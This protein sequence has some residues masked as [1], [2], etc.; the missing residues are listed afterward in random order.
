MRIIRFDSVGGASGDMILGALI[1][2]GVNLDELNAEL[3]TLVPEKFEI[4]T[5]PWQSYGINN[6]IQAEVV[7]H[8]HEHHHHHHHEDHGHEHHHHHGRNF[9]D[10][11]HLIDSSGLED[12]VKKMS[13]EVFGAL[14][15]AEAKVHG[16][17]P[18]EVHFH[19]VGA[20]D[21]IVDIVG[22]CLAFC[23]LEADAISV[24]PLPTG[25]GTFDC[26]HGTY[27]LPAPATM[28]MLKHG[29][30]T[31]PT[32]EPY[33]LLTPTGAALL[34][35]W[36]KAEIG[37]DAVIKKSA[38]SFGHRELKKRPNLLRASIYEE[39]EKLLNTESLS[40]LETNIDDSTPELIGYVFDKLLDAGALDV[41]T[42]A[43]L[44]KKQ[45]Q[46][47]MLSV[48][49]E[50]SK[51]NELINLILTET[52]SLG[53]REYKVERNCLEYRFEQKTTPYGDV[54][55]KIASHK[56]RD[57]TISPEFDDCVRLAEKCGVPLKE[58][59][60]IASS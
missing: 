15:E 59:M 51:N 5:Q 24:S 28:E 45:R 12:K 30:K 2:L 44:M 52:S 7:I 8:K 13:L 40:V 36:P 50:K 60:R 11:K 22:C 10:I 55:V 49:C 58:I 54:K 46:G 14:A 32:D 26:Q 1:G 53:V 20:V 4:R 27:P 38:D 18:D 56:G 57:L 43:V 16:K 42:N 37:S 35:I 21:S 31:A 6:G 41:W 25:T 23:K 9:H 3:A 33:E 39:S 47:V 19:E 17:S 34:A 29:L 48:L